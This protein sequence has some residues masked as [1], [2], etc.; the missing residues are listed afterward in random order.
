MNLFWGG[1]STPKTTKTITLWIAVYPS[2]MALIDVKLWENVLQTIPDISFFDAQAFFLAFF[3][4][5]LGVI[6]FQESCILEELEFFRRHWQISRRKSLPIVCLFFLYDP[7]RRGKSRTDRFC[8]WLSAKNVF[9]TKP[10][11]LHYNLLMLWRKTNKVSEKM[12]RH[13][14]I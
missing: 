10:F 3:F 14:K 12:K 11:W 1:C 7:W 8:S 6:F 4:K 13:Q 2:N 5:N 9:H